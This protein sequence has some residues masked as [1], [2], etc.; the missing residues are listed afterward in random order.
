MYGTVK[1]ALERLTGSLAAE[2]HGD[3]IAVNAAAPLKPVPTP[4]AGTLDLA[5]EDTE[6]IDAD[7]RDG[8]HPLHGRSC[9]HDGPGR[10]HPALPSGAG[11]WIERVGAEHQLHVGGEVRP[12]TKAVAAVDGDRLAGDPAGLVREQEADNVG[13][14]LG[15][16]YPTE[17]R[18]VHVAV[19]DR[20]APLDG[21]H[22]LGGDEARL[23]GV[24]AHLHG[25]VFV[26]RVAH[27][28]LDA[29]L[30][31][32]VGAEVR[33][34]HVA[35]DGGHAHERATAR[36]REMRDRVL[37]AQQR[38]E[39]VQV[40]HTDELV[41]VLQVVRA[42]AATASCVGDDAVEAVA[43]FDRGCDESSDVVLAVTSATTTL[44]SAPSSRIV[45]ADSSRRLSVRPQIV[46]RAPSAAALRAHAAPM[47]V[48]PP[49][50]MTERPS[51]D[52]PVMVCAT[53]D[54]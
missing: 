20:A 41:H 22:D 49:V 19:P 3:G 43:E 38:A 35:G 8:A 4:G 5:K 36:R 15:L 21:L 50:T 51:S 10:L 39:D 27:H 6:D 48:P 53:V 40:E 24:E 18:L 30:R 45:A 34:G 46:T 31:D 7:R 54:G 47:P 17:G 28:R 29:R 13:D 37:D 23:H 26:G 33:V 9:R 32:R 16:A 52:L 12:S 1:A 42:K 11:A 44:T 14:V 2:L 25:S